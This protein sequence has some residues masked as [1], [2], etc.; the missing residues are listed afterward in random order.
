MKHRN[1]ALYD[2]KPF[3]SIREA[4]EL[5]GLSCYHLRTGIKAGKIRA[6]QSGSKYFIDIYRFIESRD[7]QSA[8]R[9]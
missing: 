7:T 5:T 1:L 4:A 8:S 6:I 9:G 2:G 3:L